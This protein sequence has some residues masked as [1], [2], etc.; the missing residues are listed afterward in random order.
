MSV[1]SSATRLPGSNRSWYSHIEMTISKNPRRSLRTQI[2]AAEFKS[3]CLSLM[4]E[5]A[6][7]GRSFTVTKRGKPVARLVPVES[8]PVPFIGSLK[9]VVIE[10]ID[11]TEPT[12][13]KWEAETE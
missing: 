3:R 2:S 5:V 11:L 12:G 10:A 13:E 7:H 4:D 9:G 1:G 8:K 6:M